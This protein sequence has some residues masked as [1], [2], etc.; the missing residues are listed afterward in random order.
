LGTIW[1]SDRTGGK[2]LKEKPLWAWAIPRNLPLTVQAQ[3]VFYL[4]PFYTE[5]LAKRPAE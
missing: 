1:I 5:I 3:D 4:L 2:T